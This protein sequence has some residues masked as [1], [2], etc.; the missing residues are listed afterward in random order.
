MELFPVGATYC[1]SRFLHLLPGSLE[2]QRF[3]CFT[4]LPRLFRRKAK[5]MFP[6][7]YLPDFLEE[8]DGAGTWRMW[9]AIWIVGVA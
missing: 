6:E 5:I 7:G 3:F 2:E 1:I 8:G 9:K 4:I